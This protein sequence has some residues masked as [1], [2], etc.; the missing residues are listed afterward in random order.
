MSTDTRRQARPNRAQSLVELLVGLACLIPIMLVIFDLAVILIAVQMNDSTCR[1]A[2]RVA[3]AGSPTDI[4][5]RA[6]AIISRANTRAKGMMQNIQMISCT[7]TTPSNYL[8]NISQF[9]GPIYGT[10]TVQT[11]VDVYPFIVQWAYA[12]K[13]PMKFRSQ[14][15]FPFTYVVPNTTGTAP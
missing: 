10:V 2:A 15:S 4:Q 7:S 11:E 5:T 3:A 13:S 9:G 8:S 1:E 6:G 12:G 14:Q